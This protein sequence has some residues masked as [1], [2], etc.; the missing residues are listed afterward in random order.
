MQGGP[1]NVILRSFDAPVVRRGSYIKCY[2]GRSGEL[3][4]DPEIDLQSGRRTH[5]DV[6]DEGVAYANRMASLGVEVSHV[7]FPGQFHGFFSLPHMLGEAR[8]AH[9]LAAEA[10]VLALATPA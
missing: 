1:G 8:T 4:N 9:A 10:L 7:E 3:H 2:I 6:R 5:K